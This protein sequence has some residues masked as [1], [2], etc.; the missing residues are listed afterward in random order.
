[1]SLRPTTASTAAAPTTAATAAGWLPAQDH[2]APSPLPAWVLLLLLLLLLG[3]P[4]LL[5]RSS[6]TTTVAAG[7]RTH[8]A[9]GK[10]HRTAR[11]QG[12]Q[13]THACV[14]QTPLCDLCPSSSALAALDTHIA[15]W[16]GMSACS[17]PLQPPRWLL[18]RHRARPH[19]WALQ[20]TTQ[21]NSSTQ[22]QP[23]TCAEHQRPCA[24]G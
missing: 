1:V 22:H 13:S 8:K 18:W 7:R 11:Q 16:H 15:V 23:R 20:N 24:C 21:H 6:S 4:L 3:R 19:P 2:Q 5:A 17:W 12:S 9:A 10:T 14:L